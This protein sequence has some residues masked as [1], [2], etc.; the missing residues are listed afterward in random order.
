MASTITS[1]DTSMANLATQFQTAI[2]TTIEAESAPLNRVKSLKE[3]L[4]VRRS[5]YNDIK[6]NF[7]ALQSAVQGLIS[8]QSSYGLSLVSKATV[9]PATSGSTV[10]SVSKTSETA[11]VTDYDFAV[12]KLA[13]ANSRATNAF[14]SPD[15]ALNKIGTLWLGG[16]GVA[17]LQSET[18]PGVYSNFV[19]TTSVTGASTSIVSSGQR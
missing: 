12:T 19:A 3:S 7:D 10:F 5:V 2:K 16:T 17:A 9:T 4:D 15:V 1:I 8:S 18:T 11:D 13:R 14:S 6:T